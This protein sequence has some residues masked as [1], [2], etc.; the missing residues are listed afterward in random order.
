MADSQS[1]NYKYPV[2][3]D[4]IPGQVEKCKDL[5][6]SPGPSEKTKSKKDIDSII[7]PLKM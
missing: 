2:S 3:K 5:W 1:V 7:L 6:E 4:D